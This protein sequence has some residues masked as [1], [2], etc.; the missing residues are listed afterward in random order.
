MVGALLSFIMMAVA[1]REQSFELNTFQIMF[2]RSVAGLLIVAGLFWWQGWRLAKTRRFRDHVV[3][4]VI[5]FSAQYVWLYGIA[6]LPLAQVFA[7]EFTTPIWVCILAVPMLGEA[8]TRWR[9]ISI[10]LGFIGVMVV[11]RPGTGETTFD[12]TTLVVMWCAVGFAL[13]NINTKRLVRTDAP[14]TIMFYMAVIQL[15]IGFFP[16]LAQGWVWPTWAMLP[17]I[18]VLGAAAMSAHFCL[19]Q[20]LKIADAGLVVPMDFMRLPLIAVVGFL[21]YNEVFD[22][23]ILVGAVIIVIGNVINIRAS[24]E[25]AKTAA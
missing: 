4:N 14:L 12:L 5:H 18:F 11:L 17:W 2:Y 10:L 20:A 15:P 25:T 19:A 7:I 22:P 13:T 23:W 9:V 8:L 6:V 3:R 16:S 24:K 1:G 21:L